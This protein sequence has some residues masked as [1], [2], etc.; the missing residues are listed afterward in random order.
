MATTPNHKSS[1]GRIRRIDQ[2][3]GRLSHWEAGKGEQSLSSSRREQPSPSL[4]MLKEEQSFFDSAPRSL[5]PRSHDASPGHRLETMVE[6]SHSGEREKVTNTRKWKH[7]GGERKQRRQR[8]NKLP[9][10]SVFPRNGLPSGGHGS[11][12]G[13][14][15]PA[16]DGTTLDVW[17]S[18]KCF[19]LKPFLLF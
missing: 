4:Q 16:L 18:G 15:Y 14:G 7:G 6:D 3:L 8:L 9:L 11:D 5:S 19:S 2:T 17:R 12:G 13:D 1:P 10:R